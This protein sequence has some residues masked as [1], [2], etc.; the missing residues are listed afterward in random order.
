MLV[1]IQRRSIGKLP[2]KSIEN[3][4]SIYGGKMTRL[5][6]FS[7]EY[8]SQSDPAKLLSQ[9]LDRLVEL[10]QLAEQS[11]HALSGNGHRPKKAAKLIQQLGNDRR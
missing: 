5:G 2:V 1:S 6:N 10:G 4:M 3:G 7:L 9:L 8:F 11:S